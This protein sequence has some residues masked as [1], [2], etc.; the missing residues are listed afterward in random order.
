MT[1]KIKN[2]KQTEA[3]SFQVVS[4][5]IMCSDPCYES[6]DVLVRAKNGEWIARVEKSDEGSW[7]HRVARVLVHHVDFS[8]YGSSR[9]KAFDSVESATIGVDSGQAGVFDANSFRND[10]VVKNTKR[11]YEKTICGDELWYSI[12]CDRTCSK[13]GY[14][15]IPGGFVT[16]SGYGDGGYGVE[17]YKKNGE[18]VAVEIT[19]IEND[20]EEDEED[21]EDC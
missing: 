14:G 9:I 6:G 15:Y 5:K 12:C 7:G 19:F 18:A 4:G 11:I 2:K 3:E 20:D 10:T 1:T 21:C 16:T 17:I 13:K 8:M